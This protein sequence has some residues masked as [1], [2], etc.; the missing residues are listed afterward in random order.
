MARLPGKTLKHHMISRSFMAGCLLGLAVFPTETSASSLTINN[1][2]LE[3][4]WD[5]ATGRF[6]MFAKPGQRNFVRE[7]QLSAAGGVGKRITVTDKIFGRGPALEIVYANGSRD[8]IMVFPK[9]P[10]AL[11]PVVV[12]TE[13][14]RFQPEKEA[15]ERACARSGRGDYANDH[16]HPLGRLVEEAMRAHLPA[17]CAVLFRCKIAEHENFGP[18]VRPPDLPQDVD[19]VDLT[20]HTS[21]LE[22]RDGAAP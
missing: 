5:G 20:A 19:A 7:G 22:H 12:D 16:R 1:S 8:V 4:R 18:W 6:A 10:L 11:V 3:V 14:F 17:L 15:T 21:S 9:L 2:A 13:L